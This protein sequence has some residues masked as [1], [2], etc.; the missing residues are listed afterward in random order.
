VPL[1][2]KHATLILPCL[3][4]TIRGTAPENWELALSFVPAPPDMDLVPIHDAAAAQSAT[5]QGITVDLENIVVQGDSHIFIFSLSW[6]Q[7]GENKP[8]LYP[9]SI[10]VTDATGRTIRLL[11]DSGRPPMSQDVSEPFTFRTRE[12]PAPGPLTLNLD[13]IRAS[14]PVRG[15]SFTIEPGSDPQPNQVWALDEHL[16]VAGYEWDVT[17]AQ[18][19]TQDGME[20]LE[21]SMQSTNPEDVMSVDLLDRQHPIFFGAGST[22]GTTFTSS[23]YYEDGVPAGSITVTVGQV[24]ALISGDWRIRWVP[25]AE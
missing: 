7:G 2:V 24:S 17:S 22:E 23:F 21:F 4:D 1:D 14:F 10:H 8:D 18:V 12:M 11:D 13:A 3:L 25:P 16:N 9:A 19:V 20:G 5:D 6:N 15:V